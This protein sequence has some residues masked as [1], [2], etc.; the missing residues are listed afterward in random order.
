[1]LNG[2]L[3]VELNQPSLGGESQ[4]LAQLLLVTLTLFAY[5]YQIA[6]GKDYLTVLHKQD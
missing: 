1:M 2:N 6:F 4:P 3:D 5:G